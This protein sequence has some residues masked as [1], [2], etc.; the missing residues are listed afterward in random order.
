MTECFFK[1]SKIHILL[2]LAK[3]KKT[4]QV[5][6]YLELKAGDGAESECRYTRGLQAGLETDQSV[7]A[8]KCTIRNALCP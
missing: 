2:I 5:K 7:A 1:V 8:D 6:Q 3:Q 4:I